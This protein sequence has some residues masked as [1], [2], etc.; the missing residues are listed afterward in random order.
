MGII[1]IWKLKIE[2]MEKETKLKDN[3]KELKNG[4]NTIYFFYE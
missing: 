2:M 4:Y 1:I 3:L